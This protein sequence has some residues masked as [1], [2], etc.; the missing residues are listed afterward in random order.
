MELMEAIYHRRSVRHYSRQPVARATIMELLR[1]AV[2]APNAA[3]EQPWA[4]AIVR[5][6]KRLEEYSARAK[7]YILT[8][9]P[10]SLA[11]HHRLDQLVDPDYNVFHH[12]GTLIVIYAKPAHYNP[13]EDCCMAAQNLLL[14]AHGMSLGSCPV[15]FA[16]PWFNLDEIKY[17]HGIPQNYTAVMPIV[18][19]WPA[20]TAVPV[21]RDEPEIAS[22]A[23]SS[24]EQQD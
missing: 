14:A 12:A 17:D 5:G 2:Q 9:L 1:A 8:T 16:R 13:A 10:Q 21:P 7:Q 22:W 23:E 18:L 3:N 24:S 19:G 4:F 11:L 15:G 6:R 20:G